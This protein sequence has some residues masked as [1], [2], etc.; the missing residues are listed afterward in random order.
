M[1]EYKGCIGIDLGTTYSCVAY[2]NDDHVEIIPNNE[3]GRHTTPSWVAF[4]DSEILVG[5]PAKR[6]AGIN[7]RNTIYD[8][9][10]II[11]KRYTDDDLQND[12]ENFYFNIVLVS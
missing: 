5:D 2:W 3:T 6:Q 1:D 11:G 12:L 7:L 10:R 4:T 9:K 8:N